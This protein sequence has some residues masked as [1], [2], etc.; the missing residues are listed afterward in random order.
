MA[1]SG[2]ICTVRDYHN[3]FAKPYAAR[4]EVRN[5]LPDGL[6]RFLNR[7]GL[8]RVPAA[9]GWFKLARVF[10]A[11]TK[12]WNLERWPKPH[13]GYDLSWARFPRFFLRFLGLR[14]LA[15]VTRRN[16]L[17]L[18]RLPA[19]A[20]AAVQAPSADAGAPARTGQQVES[21]A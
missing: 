11:F 17:P 13:Q 1:E 8:W 2:D 9:V 6:A 4:L 20:P 21:A 16:T 14:L 5:Y 19:L 3:A 10:Y 15:M 12:A 18:A 7:T